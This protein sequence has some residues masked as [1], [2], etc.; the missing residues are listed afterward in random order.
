MR[1]LCHFA[2]LEE[3]VGQEPSAPDTFIYQVLGQARLGAG[4]LTYKLDSVEQTFL[5]VPTWSDR[6]V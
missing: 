5:S 1:A 6:N 2:S 4:H 3:L